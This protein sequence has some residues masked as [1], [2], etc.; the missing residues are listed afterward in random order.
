MDPKEIMKWFLGPEVPWAYRMLF[1]LTLILLLAGYFLD[2]QAS[3][4]QLVERVGN[5]TASSSATPAQV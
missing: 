3:T 4:F 2:N 1:A 5:D